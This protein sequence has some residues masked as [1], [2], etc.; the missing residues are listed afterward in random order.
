M[1]K[2]FSLKKSALKLMCVLALPSI[3][4]AADIYVSTKGT[5]SNPGTPVAP[6]A[7]LAAARDLVKTVAGKAAVTVHVADGIY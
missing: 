5:D 6:V 1:K 7:T 4:A 3:A 2:V